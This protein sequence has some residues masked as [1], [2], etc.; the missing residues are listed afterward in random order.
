MG[1]IHCFAAHLWSSPL[2]LVNRPYASTRDQR[3]KYG[4]SPASMRSVNCQLYFVQIY[5]KKKKKKLYF[6]QMEVRRRRHDGPDLRH[7]G[8]VELAGQPA[9]STEG[10]IGTLPS[11]R[12]HKI[13][14][15]FA[16]P[17][18]TLCNRQDFTV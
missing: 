11:R 15:K 13:L 14:R 7:T 4:S 12:S 9:V 10:S 6:V 5:L 3:P 1:L 2:H 8:S 17:M 16:D 18:N